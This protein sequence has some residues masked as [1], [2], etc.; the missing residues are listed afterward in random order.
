MSRTPR[1]KAGR[2]VLEH[3]NPTGRPS[4]DAPGFLARSGR[5]LYDQDAQWIAWIEDEASVDAI[6]ALQAIKRDEG[7][8]CDEYETCEHRACQSSYAAWAIADAALR[9]IA[10]DR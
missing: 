10:G 7:K 4:D 3:W 9:K 5:G 6:D 2:E 8:V 1:T